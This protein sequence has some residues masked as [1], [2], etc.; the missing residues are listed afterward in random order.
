MTQDLFF[1]CRHIRLLGWAMMGMI[2]SMT[3]ADY[4]VSEPSQ[5]KSVYN[6]TD[7][8]PLGKHG[9]LLLSTEFKTNIPNARAW[10]ILYRST[11]IHNNPVLS[12]GML[13][14]PTGKVAL[15]KRPVVSF[16][17]G[18]T[19]IAPICAPSSIEDPAT[20]PQMYFYA[21]T[22]SRKIMDTGIPGLSKMIA[23][24]Y[25]VVATDYS[26]LGAPG[27]H[28]YLVGPTAARNTLDAIAAAQK[29][30]AS[31]SG[32][33]AVVIGWSE[34]GQAA[35]WSAEI[36]DYAV[37]TELLGV[38]ALAP[39]NAAEQLKIER[40]VTASGK[41]LPAMTDT[42]TLMAQ[43]ASAKTFS[44]L[45]LSDVFTPFGIEFMDEASKHQCSKQMSQSMQYM[46]GQKG[47][48][49]RSDPQNQ[50]AWLKR[51]EQMGL[52]NQIAK[53]P[54]AIYQ[55]DDDPTIFPAATGA[56]I[57][58]A[59]ANGSNVTYRHY[60]KTDH[61]GVVFAAESDYL[62]WIANRFSNKRATNECHVNLPTKS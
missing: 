31:G 57:K 16:A 41:K 5:I 21:S 44:D 14:A 1:K 18:T 52:G 32:T 47:P 17:H 12:T 33:K 23:A 37:N 22:D 58:K 39:V 48:L 49:S 51:T 34:G 9:D 2:G 35:V 7:T 50:E 43:Y 8:L 26:G 61:L 62:S 55:G 40:Q 54:V 3:I 53:V 38:V 10:K 11:D 56:Y 46:A 59:C 6:Y 19:G 4:A 45:Q 60:P 42:E 24:G 20:D 28:Q 13:I 25:V 15:G 30:S 36:A 27:L 29:L